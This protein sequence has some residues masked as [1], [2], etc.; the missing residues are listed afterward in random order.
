MICVVWGNFVHGAKRVSPH[1]SDWPVFLYNT[2]HRFLCSPR[3]TLLGYF[4]RIWTFKVQAEMVIPTPVS[5]ERE[6]T[7]KG[8]NM[9]RSMRHKL[10]S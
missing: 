9:V 7:R 4:V 8:R 6:L 10:P 5:C 2:K 1:V 3:L